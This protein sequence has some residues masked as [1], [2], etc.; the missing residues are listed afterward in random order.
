MESADDAEADQTLYVVISVCALAARQDIN[1]KVRRFVINRN[2]CEP[3]MIIMPGCKMLRTEWHEVLIACCLRLTSTV[4]TV[5]LNI[6]C[7]VLWNERIQNSLKTHISCCW[8]T[9]ATRCITA[10][11]LQTKKVNAHCDKLA[12]ELVSKLESRQF[13]ATAPVS[14]FNLRYLPRLQLAPPFRVT[15]FDF[16][17]DCLHCPP[18]VFFRR[19]SMSAS[20]FSVNPIQRNNSLGSARVTHCDHKHKHNRLNHI[21]IA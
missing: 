10:N 3:L 20:A 7:A 8:Q 9:R 13:S 16:C 2:Q 5:Q 14:L 15:P 11:V 17:R 1:D 21:H 4:Y 18:S 19:P 12:T 6:N